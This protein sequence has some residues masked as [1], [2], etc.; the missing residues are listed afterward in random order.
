MNNKPGV[1]VMSVPS[2][3]IKIGIAHDAWD[4]L[5]TL[6]V[7][8]AEPIQL[9]DYFTVPEYTG[10]ARDIE[11]AMH[12]LLSPFRARGE[13][14]KASLEAVFWAKKVA[15]YQLVQPKT[16]NRWKRLCINPV[17]TARYA[18]HRVALRARQKAPE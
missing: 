10:T 12:T 17:F 4:R 11:Q 9:I 13:W 15:V 6:Q 2:G 14:F 3:H 5:S 7:G 1:Y 8:N 18:S 16:F